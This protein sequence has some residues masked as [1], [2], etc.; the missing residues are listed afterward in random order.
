VFLQAR[1]GLRLAQQRHADALGDAAASADGWR[2]LGFENPSMATWRTSA[3]AAHLAE[4]RAAEAAAVAGEQLALARATG[5]S[6]AFA[7]ALRASA[8]VGMHPGGN[9]DLPAAEQALREAGGIFESFGA[10]HDLGLTLAD[11][12]ACLRRAGRVSEAREPLRRALD[13][14]EKTGGASLR[15]YAKRELVAAGVRP[16]RAALAG[17]DALTNA[18]RQIAGLAAAGR[19]NKQI[20]QHLFVTTGTVET[21]LRHIFQKLDITSRTEIPA[22]LASAPS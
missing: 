13:L 8:W 6:L 22:K 12:G 20:A 5:A 1:A 3:V 4:G 10:R 21:H 9:N 18:E 11:L 2:A 17:P 14:A 7:T 15:D 19:S 16:R